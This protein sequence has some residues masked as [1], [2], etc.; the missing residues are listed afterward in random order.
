VIFS[1]TKPEKLAE[2]G[3]NGQNERAGDDMEL[4]TIE[5]Y[6]A[7]EMDAKMS[8]ELGGDDT[9]SEITAKVAPPR[10]T[11]LAPLTTHTPG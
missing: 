8:Q 4:G 7:M 10:H 9:T 2:L 6:A 1:R 3:R 5:S 11:S